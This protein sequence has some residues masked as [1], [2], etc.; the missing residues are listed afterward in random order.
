MEYSIK[1]WVWLQAAVNQY[2]NKCSSKHNGHL[3]RVNWSFHLKLQLHDLHEIPITITK[4]EHFQLQLQF[5][6][7]L[8][9]K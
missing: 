7:Q 3:D 1:C 6:F 9:L 5:L 2:P 4:N 8:Q